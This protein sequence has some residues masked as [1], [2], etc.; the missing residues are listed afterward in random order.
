MRCNNCGI[1]FRY[2][3]EDVCPKCGSMDVTYQKEDFSYSKKPSKRKRK[4]WKIIAIILAILLVLVIGAVAYMATHEPPWI[5]TEVSTNLSGS[6]TIST[7]ES[8]TQFLPT[9]DEYKAM[10]ITVS[11]NDIERNPSAYEGVDVKF[12]GKVI[13][14]SEEDDGTTYRI[15]VTKDAYDDYDDPVL[16]YYEREDGEARILEDDIVTFYGE[17]RGVYTY[18]SVWGDQ[19]TVPAVYALIMEIDK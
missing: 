10:C 3:G 17:C 9:K 13:Q 19:V 12:T 1:Q 6:M 16:V 8:T 2:D 14:V 5:D 7:E 11:Y 15:S 4:G 18:E